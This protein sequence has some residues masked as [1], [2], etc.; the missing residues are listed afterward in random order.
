MRKVKVMRVGHG[1]LGNPNAWRIERKIN[2]W[3]RKGFTLQSTQ[4]ER[5]GCIGRGY[6]L[7]TFVRDA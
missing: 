2:K 6:T 5:G 1:L 7:L 4:D 3:A